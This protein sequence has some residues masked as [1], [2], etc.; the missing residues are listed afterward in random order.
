LQIEK[1]DRVITRSSSLLVL[2]TFEKPLNLLFSSYFYLWH[3][4][5][6]KWPWCHNLLS[7]CTFHSWTS[8]NL[9]PFWTSNKRRTN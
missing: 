9:Q 8:S 3:F 5:F 4:F 7:S 2:A 1:L 6:A